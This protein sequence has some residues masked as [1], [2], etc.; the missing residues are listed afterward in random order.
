MPR[1]DDIL[2]V[3]LE[4][5]ETGVPL[6]SVLGEVPERFSE[7]S[8]LIQLAAA[9]REHPVPEPNF[10][11]SLVRDVRASMK[12]AEAPWTRWRDTFQ[13]ILSP[14]GYQLAGAALA[15]VLLIV[16]LW[17]F[18]F[19]FGRTRNARRV[20]LIEVAG[21]VEVSS[22]ES[23]GD[24][25][26]VSDGQEIKEGQR[27]RTGADSTATLLFYEGS[28]TILG[29]NTD[30][31]LVNAR[32]DGQKSVN[33]SIYQYRGDTKHSVVPFE[34]EKSAY[35]VDTPTGSA[36]V[37]GTTFR[38]LVPVED[39]TRFSV[40]TGVVLVE[41]QNEQ[42][43]LT[44][45]QATVAQAGQPLKAPAYQFSLEGIL[46]ENDQDLWVVDSV[47]FLVAPETILK[48]SPQQGDFVRVD[49]RALK[50]GTW[51]ADIVEV[52]GNTQSKATFT[53]ILQSMGSEWTISRANVLVDRD[54]RIDAS[55]AIGD[56]VEI[57]FIVLDDGRWK[58]LSATRFDGT[59]GCA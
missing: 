12:A 36:N 9:I 16:S 27:L 32:G 28:R 48:G 38:V 54:T 52:V 13:Q 59:N 11:E 18:G 51:V 30:L 15:V 2:Q 4:A 53:G 40:D 33:I 6:D 47:A 39:V 50:D 1:L 19:W 20:S 22:G 17:S 7:L 21:I 25:Q 31:V 49:G 26:G 56:P 5:L 37:H 35:R 41:S 24:W 42:V 14:S 44:A 57:S 8:K 43:Y 55:L 10:S 3:H 23:A 46:G 45:G 34:S 29:S 58:A